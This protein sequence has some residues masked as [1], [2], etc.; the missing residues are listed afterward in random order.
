MR[1]G[2]CRSAL[3]SGPNGYGAEKASDLRETALLFLS[4]E[5]HGNEDHARKIIAAIV[6]N[7]NSGGKSG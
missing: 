6:E 2:W 1:K 4:R 3:E 7:R 5:D